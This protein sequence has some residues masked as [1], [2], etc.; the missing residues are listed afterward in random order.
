M[1]LRHYRRPLRAMQVL[2]GLDRPR[3]DRAERGRVAALLIAPGSG[4][5][6][7]RVFVSRA[8]VL[9]STAF[10]R[11][12]TVRAGSTRLVAGLYL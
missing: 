5:A 1:N 2:V 4:E 3:V 10:S 9:L 8:T 11:T 12:A 6:D 7:D